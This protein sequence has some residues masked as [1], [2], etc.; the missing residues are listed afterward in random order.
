MRKG[1]LDALRWNDIDFDRGLAM[2]HETKN[3]S[4][5]YTPI[6]EVTMDEVKKYREVG[7][8]PKC[9]DDIHALIDSALNIQKLWLA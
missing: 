4:V 7:N 6:P 1:E 5:R 3:G 9:F 8:S 2:L